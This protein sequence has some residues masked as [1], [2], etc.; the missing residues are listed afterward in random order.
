M[1]EIW[2]DCGPIF[3]VQQ[4]KP[5]KK[6]TFVEMIWV[7]PPKLGWKIQN[8]P[9]PQ[10][11]KKGAILPTSYWWMFLAVFG[12]MSYISLLNLYPE[13]WEENWRCPCWVALIFVHMLL[14]QRLHS[15]SMEE[16]FSGTNH[17]RV[18]TTLRLEVWS[19][20]KIEVAS[21]ICI[22]DGFCKSSPKKN[23]TT[24]HEMVG[25]MIKQKYPNERL[26]EMVGTKYYPL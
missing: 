1:E 9:T 6:Q 25:K 14:A 23:L 13:I 26:L 7:S 15:T 19:H 8:W 17:Q 2:R 16:F 12:V 18:F 5:C 11:P 21:L 4:N 3:Q 24:L 20:W 22:F 10:V